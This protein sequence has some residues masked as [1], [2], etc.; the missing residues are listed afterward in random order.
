MHSSA[1]C[2][3]CAVAFVSYLSSPLVGG[4]IRMATVALLRRRCA[5]QSHT[6]WV[7]VYG[8]DVTDPE[9]RFRTIR[10]RTH[11]NETGRSPDGCAAALRQQKTRPPEDRG[12]HKF[13]GLCIQ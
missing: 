10:H 4:R 2:H 5:V 3:E 7:A 13:Q 6:V 8:G 12:E 9:T 11:R 1:S